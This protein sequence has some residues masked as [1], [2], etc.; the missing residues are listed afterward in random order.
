[1]TRNSRFGPAPR[2]R[3][4]HPPESQLQTFK[5]VGD[6]F[7][8]LFWRKNLLFGL[9][10]DM[11]QGE[12]KRL[13]DGDEEAPK[14][15]LLKSCYQ[16]EAEWPLRETLI[17]QSINKQGAIGIPKVVAGGIA[18]VADE[19]RPCSH[20]DELVSTI[21][22]KV[23]RVLLL[24]ERS[25]NMRDLWQADSVSHL[26][27]GI[28]DDARAIWSAWTLGVHHRDISLGNLEL[29][30]FGNAKFSDSQFGVD[31]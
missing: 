31:P 6:A 27:R 20:K 22:G 23:Y 2:P 7:P 24:W 17:L 12:I 14:S 30:G 3:V 19:H 13:D 28:H 15:V 1:M 4:T 18:Q 8:T 5:W 9:M 29:T 21:G 25:G 16:A 11:Y 26:F 10:T